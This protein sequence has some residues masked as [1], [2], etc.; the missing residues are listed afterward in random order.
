[1]KREELKAIEAREEEATPGPWGYDPAH[2]ECEN[3]ETCP[4][5]LERD[6]RG[7]ADECE[8]CDHWYLEDS[9]SLSGP[10]YLGDHGDEGFRTK[11]AEF[12]AHSRQ[13]VPALIAEVKRLERERDAAIADLREADNCDYCRHSSLSNTDHPCTNCFG[14]DCDFWEW[15]GVQA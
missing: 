11:D 14:G 8:D 3:T 10:T 7:S 12:I 5:G 6:K 13:D 9:A 15:R 4:N 2:G 1:M